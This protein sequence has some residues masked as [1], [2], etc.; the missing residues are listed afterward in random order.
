MLDCWISESRPVLSRESERESERG[1][2][3]VPITA[4]S[5]MEKKKEK[6]K[7][8][9]RFSRSVWLWLSVVGDINFDLTSK[10]SKSDPLW[11]YTT[12]R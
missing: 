4:Q 1:R 6:G 8:R 2:L 5:A 11:I 7:T 10:K 3:S 12:K 9:V